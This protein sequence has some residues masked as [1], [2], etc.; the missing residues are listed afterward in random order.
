MGWGF[1][2]LEVM[3][4]DARNVRNGWK[5]LKAVDTTMI[6]VFWRWFLT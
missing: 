3:V 1:S 6:A 2:Y 4:M 5:K